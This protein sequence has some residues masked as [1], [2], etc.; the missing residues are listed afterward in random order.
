MMLRIKDFHSD[1]DDCIFY[2]GIN[3]YFI[4][5]DGKNYLLVV[6]KMI[7]TNTGETKT[8]KYICSS[9]HTAFEQIELMEDRE[10]I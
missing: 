9:L 10:E 2:E 5:E 8:E 7:D 1:Y 6:E 4:Y 3:H